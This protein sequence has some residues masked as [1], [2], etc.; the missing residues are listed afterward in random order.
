M[1]DFR[2]MKWQP[3]HSTNS[4]GKSQLSPRITVIAAIDS[5]G[6]IYITL[7]QANTNNQTMALYLRHL[8]SKL[9]KERPGWRNHYLC[10][11]DN[12]PYHTSNA[13]I[14][15]CEK[16]NFPVCFTGPHSY[17]ACPAEL[18]F[19]AFKSTAFNEKNIP[20][21]KTHFLELMRLVIDRFCEIPLHHRLLF[22]HH[23][24]KELYRYLTFPDL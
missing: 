12:A 4:V 17:D 22:W 23:C 7:M 24:L 13:T 9:D 1:S 6:E 11:L 2:R 21:G 15:L 5:K 20:T 16:L 14:K 3:K 19:A 10:V 18:L 8:C